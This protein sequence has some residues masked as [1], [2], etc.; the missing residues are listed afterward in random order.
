ML[1]SVFYLAS[2]D[3]GSNSAPRSCEVIDEVRGLREGSSYLL[4]AIEPPLAMNFNTGPDVYFRKLIL[5]LVEPG[6]IDDI[7]TKSVLADVVVC[8]TYSE[9]TVDERKCSKIGIGSLHATYLEAVAH[10]PGGKG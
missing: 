1:K 10:S 2:H 8:P 7:G 4:V 9:G 5:S 6:K 3:F